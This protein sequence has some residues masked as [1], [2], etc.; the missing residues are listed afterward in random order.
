MNKQYLKYLIRQNRI[1]YLFFGMLYAG[2]TLAVFISWRGSQDVLGMLNESLLIASGLGIVLTYILPAVLLSFVHR[3]RSADLYFSLPIKRSELLIT[4]IVFIIGL[5]WLYFTVSMTAAF[6]LAPLMDP[7]RWAKYVLAMG[8]IIATLT[9]YHSALFLVANNIFDGVVMI[10]AYTFFPLVLFLTVEAFTNA[11]IAG[12][13][14]Y[15]LSSGIVELF[16]PFALGVNLLTSIV[17]SYQ[18]LIPVSPV[19]PLLLVL[20]AVISALALRK[21]FVYRQ[22][23]RAEQVSDG[24]FSYPFVIHIYAFCIL[25]VLAA[26]QPS[27]FYLQSNLVWYLIL[28][29]IYI[30][31]MFVY[32][33]KVQVR[34]KDLAVYAGGVVLTLLL[35][36]AA[37][38]THGFGLADHYRTDVGTNLVYYYYANV[39]AADLGKLDNYE[40]GRTANVTVQI[41][42]P[43]VQKEAYTEVMELFETKR[44]E[45][46]DGFYNPRSGYTCTLNVCN[47]TVYH[48]GQQTDYITDN[49][50]RYQIYTPF[51]EEELV[52]LSE[53][54]EIRVYYDRYVDET[55]NYEDM[56]LEQF[57]ERRGN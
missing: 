12:I 41:K 14:G 19:G 31:A 13:A 25:I 48:N 1:A 22:T 55:T 40:T 21:E 18:M 45:G 49:D 37:W 42:I 53:Y 35:N 50:Y 23:E 5:I 15:N 28:L 11:T 10:A 56:T 38:Q 27:F 6:L 33:R 17:R 43:L 57:L 32:R 36:Y 16:S 24:F 7:L 8:L 46:I 51:T 2:M 34:L 9:L 30:V 20:Y 47:E 39:D 3:R 4:T 52:L 54:G 44:K 29:M 26:H